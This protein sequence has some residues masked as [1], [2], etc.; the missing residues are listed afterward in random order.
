MSKI[1][2]GVPTITYCRLLPNTLS[3]GQGDIQG[4]GSNAIVILEPGQPTARYEIA[5]V[6]E[7]N[8]T[9]EEVCELTFGSRAGSN[10]VY[11]AQLTLSACEFQDEVISDL[12]RPANRGLPIVNTLEDGVVIQGLH[13][14]SVMDEVSL[15]RLLAEGCENRGMHGLPVGAGIDTSAALFDFKLY[16]TEPINSN[17]NGGS[18]SG[19]GISGGV[20]QTQE[21]ISRLMIVDLPCIDPLAS[22]GS[23]TSGSSEELRLLSGP[24]LHKSLFTFAEVVKKL[25]SPYRA[26]LAPFRG[27][28]LT[29]CL[30]EALGGNAL[31]VALGQIAPGEPQISRRTLD[32]LSGLHVA[33]H[34]PLGGREVA[35]AL[36]GLLAKYRAL[37]IQTQDCLS[38]LDQKTSKREEEQSHLIQKLQEEVADAI[39]RSGQAEEERQ[40]IFAKNLH[41]WK[42][43]IYY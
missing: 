17:H 27:S 7:K 15:R 43:I 34:Y 41:K 5:Q 32:L 33:M 29:H 18:G 13:K 9:D 30:S 11:K 19:G 25:S 31:V 22:T 39:R 37:A 35:G 42:K 3:S 6:L 36:R 2:N 8:L 16:Q 28:Q 12:L 21:C 23:T 4:D 14:E 20:F 1:P 24:N 26:Q 40:R 10:L 38:S